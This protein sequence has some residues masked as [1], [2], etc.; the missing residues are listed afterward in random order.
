MNAGPTPI[1][2]AATVVSGDDVESPLSG[3]RAAFVRLEA[4]E[5]VDGEDVSLGAILVGD[6]LRLTLDGGASLDVEVRRAELRLFG[7]R[8]GVRPITRVAAELVPLL[9]SA[10]RGGT[11]C[12]HEHL[13][14]SGARLRVRAIVEPSGTPGRV[15][16]R[17]DLAPV[18]LEELVT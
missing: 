6:L 18:I 2:L 1:D 3:R 10:R 11:L 16:A 15:V 17:H 14:P 4:L 8:A 9:A 7:P 5:R 13:V 12:E